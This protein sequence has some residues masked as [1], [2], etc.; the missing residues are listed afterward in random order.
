[1][2]EYLV[3][4][5]PVASKRYLEKLEFLGLSREEDPFASIKFIAR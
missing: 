3:A 2:G 1:M 4:L 5:P